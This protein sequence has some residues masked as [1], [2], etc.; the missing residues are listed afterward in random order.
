MRQLFGAGIKFVYTVALFILSAT[1]FISCGRESIEKTDALSSVDSLSTLTVRD[2]KIIDT[3]FGKVNMRAEAP[4]MESYSLLAEPYE[5]FREG[6]RAMGYTPEGELEIEISANMAVHLTKNDQERWEA[7][8]NVVITNHI[9]G[10]TMYTDTLYWDRVN[11]RIYTHVYV[12]LVS[13]QQGVLQG[14]GMESDERMTNAE[15]FKPFDSYGV[16]VRDTVSQASVHPGELQ[17]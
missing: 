16:M 17:Q 15:I 14:F 9:K 1:V 3:K 2:M 4:L 11:Q 12:K 8:G 7:Y 6:I 13:S 10:E 5:I